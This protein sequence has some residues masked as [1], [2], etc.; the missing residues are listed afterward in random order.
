MKPQ[1]SFHVTSS[2]KEFND[3]QKDLF[4]ELDKVNVTLPPGMIYNFENNIKDN[5]QNTKDPPTLKS[6]RG[7]ESIFKKPEVPLRRC[8]PRS[9]I[10]D[11][12]RNPHKWMKYSLNDVK[13]EDISE[14]GNKKAALT[15]LKELEDRNLVQ[16]IAATDAFS[17]KIT[18]HKSALV[19]D[20][21]KDEEKLTFKNSKVLMPEYVVG[22]K[23]KREKKNKEKTKEITSKQLT[24]SHLV[25]VDD[26]T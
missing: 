5:K 4:K 26:D 23:I 16:N 9:K 17:N 22:Q 21:D 19:A 25:E 6:F 12:K 11:F 8:L 3:K 18:F 14:A 24:L 13:D 10:P 1:S 7:K 20:A 2:H 15:F